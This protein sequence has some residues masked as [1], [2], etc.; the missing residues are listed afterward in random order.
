[1]QRLLEHD[2]D[3]REGLTEAIVLALRE[4]GQ[5]IVGGPA[6]HAPLV[7]VCGG[8]AVVQGGICAAGS[9]QHLAACQVHL[10]V[11]LSREAP[12]HWCKTNSNDPVDTKVS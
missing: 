8:A 11:G 4:P 1:M 3:V 7:I 6:R 12:A 2:S 5:H 10:Q 9:P